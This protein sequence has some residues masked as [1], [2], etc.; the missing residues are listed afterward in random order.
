[1]KKNNFARLYTTCGENISSSKNVWSKY[2]RPSLRRKIWQSLN[3]TWFID[4]EPIRVPF[5]PESILSGYE[6]EMPETYTYEKKF[7]P[8]PDFVGRILL[9]F[10]AV[11]QIAEVILNGEKIGS[12]IGG[13]LPF[14]FDVT[15][16]IK[17]QQEN[18]LQ[19]IVTD[20]LSTQ[21][22]YGKQCKKRGGMW[23]TPISG[24]WQSVWLECVPS[25]YIKNVKITPD[26]SGIHMKITLAGDTERLI[27]ED[28][29]LSAKVP[30][31]DEEFLY[32]NAFKK[33]ENNP[34]CIEGYID[35]SAYVCKDG[36]PYQP[37]YWSTEDPYLYQIELSF[38]D[39]T[40]TSYFALR[41]IGIQNINGVNRVCLNNKP[42][43]LQGVLDQGYF[44]DG[45]YTPAEEKEY[46]RDILRM[47][48]LGIN[49]IRKHIKIEPECFYYYCDVHGM[50]VFQ[51]MVNSGDYSYI[52]DTVLPAMNFLKKK[53]H[54]RRLN[55]K[56]QERHSFFT[57]HVKNTLE[58]LHNHP[59]V[60]AYTIFN[61]GWGQF[62]SDAL[63][64]M[65]KDLDGSR[66]YDSTSGWFAQMESDFDSRHI[67]FSHQK[68]PKKANDI[69]ELAARKPLF[70]SEFGGC[71]CI[72]PEHIFNATGN[73]GYGSGQNLGSFTN[74]IETLYNDIIF[75]SISLGSCG[76]VYTQLSDVE[77]ETN[78]FYTY[79]RKICKVNVPQMKSLCEKI[80]QIFEEE[81]TK[82]H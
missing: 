60:I 48:E 40:V 42:I 30:L 65:C 68:L 7:I 78:G 11:D 72:V 13:Y 55:A 23:Y 51:D 45:I 3:G 41:T 59:S 53:D 69:S 61:E 56:E 46:E 75:P 32:F 26:L 38:L 16:H 28:A 10:G 79:D 70:I 4:N 66:L 12:H 73:Y 80:A 64:R 77:D 33:Q 1:M 9:H 20:T 76:Y 36:S 24:I 29:F 35:L 67:Y 82:N 15:E 50:L 57:N 19:V 27:T 71:S 31:S 43:F 39:D 58:L 49:M 63:Y 47:K 54:T 21:Y 22:P 81:V 2:P 14:T 74:A 17:L 44:S 34:P 5:P 52:F 6:Q 25:I 18:I 62:D 8:N 37:K